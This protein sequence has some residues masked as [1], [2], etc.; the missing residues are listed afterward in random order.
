MAVIIINFIAAALALA[1]GVLRLVGADGAV[2]EIV[3]GIGWLLI[4]LIWIVNNIL[5][6]KAYKKLKESGEMNG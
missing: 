1:N 5:R 4:G 3:L 6:I 2:W